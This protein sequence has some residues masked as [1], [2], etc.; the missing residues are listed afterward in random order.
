[1][2][3]QLWLPT[4]PYTLID[5]I[6]RK[7]LATGS[8]RFAMLGARA[9]YNGHHLT[10]SFNSYRRY[11]VAEYFWAGRVVISR[12]DFA[13][14]ARAA[15]EFQKTNGRGGEVVLTVEDEEQARA[16]RA[17]GFIECTDAT[18]AAHRATYADARFD[19]INGAMS[20]EEHGLAP[21][22]GMLANSATIEEYKAKIEAFFAERKAARAL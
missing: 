14:V 6:N 3:T 5:A 10:V 18:R 19:E 1:M 22:V 12:G 20:Y 17:L 13:D 15:V 11:W 8:T 7:A 16:A 21:A 9:D 4:K 2:S